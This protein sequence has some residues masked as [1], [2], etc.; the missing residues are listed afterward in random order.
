MT[1]NSSPRSQIEYGDM[2]MER[3]YAVHLEP[4]DNGTVMA[5]VPDVPEVVT[6]GDDEA[7]AMARVADA[8]ETALAGYIQ[9]RREIPQPLAE[10]SRRASLSL[11]ATVKLA[12]YGAM[13]E[14][15]WRKA[16]L[17]RALG[18]NPRQVDRLFDLAHASSLD[19]IEAA[20]AALGKIVEPQLVA[21]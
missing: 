13:R 18:Q 14:K 9:D 11:R 12:L 8:I 1:P 15:D 3:S 2:S 20:A 6:F 10:G 19:Q 5:T 21:A 17:A 4:D 7:D 16:D